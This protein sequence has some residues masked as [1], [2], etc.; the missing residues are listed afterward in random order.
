M[1]CCPP[2]HH[3]VKKEAFLEFLQTL[4]PKFIARDDFSSKHTLWGSRLTTT[5]GRELAKAIHE[6]NYS[7]LSTGTPTYWPKD[8]GKLDTF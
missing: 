1:I 5:K 2:R 8:P 6:K 4:G 3:I 7:P